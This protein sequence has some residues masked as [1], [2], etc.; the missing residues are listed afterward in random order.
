MGKQ[1]NTPRVRDNERGAALITVVLMSMLLLMAGGALIAVSST[2]AV[3]AADATSES[4][5]YYAAE[6][7]AQAVLGVLRGNAAPSPLFNGTSSSSE[8]KISFRKAVSASQSNTSGTGT[9][10]LTR[11]LSYS[12]TSSDGTSV[13]PV[14]PSYAAASGMAFA[15]EEISDPDNSESVAFSTSGAFGTLPTNISSISFTGRTSAAV[16]ASTSGPTTIGTF[17]AISMSGGNGDF[18]VS[19]PFTLTV[20]QTAPWPKTP[21]PSKVIACT[22]SGI[23]TKTGSNVSGTLT[24]T[25]SPASFSIDG[26][27]YNVST[28]TIQAASA[29]TVNATL[30]APEPERLL[31]RVRGYGPRNAVKAMQMLVSRFAFDF[32]APSTITLRSADDGS[33]LN[34]NIGDSAVYGYNGNDNANGPSLPA[35]TVTSVPDETFVNSI[36]A[37][38]TGPTDQVQGY[39]GPARRVDVSTLDKFLQTTTGD[40]GARAVLEKMRKAAKNQKTPGCTAAS[41]ACDRYFASGESPSDIGAGSDEGLMTFVDGNYSMPPSGGAGLLI[42]T[43]TLTMTG[44]ADY[45]GLILVLGGGHVERNGGGGDMSLGAMAVACFNSTAGDFTAPTFNVQGGGNSTIRYDSEW[46]R[47][48]LKTA[49]PSVLGIS[50]Y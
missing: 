7:G 22:L 27:G 26:V 19:I 42:V 18:T 44:N 50:E 39:P 25:P 29:T 16:N 15:V 21:P 43:G 28:Q 6:A 33:V 3:N 30:T 38:N 36:N 24:L 12:A 9:P 5:A 11:W 17:S 32:N 14:S 40:Y 34:A 2:S 37:D 49:G 4:Q 20:T 41:D 1:T 45:K 23:L 35:F 48:A 46:V 8:N 13:V 10:R 31:I 47:K